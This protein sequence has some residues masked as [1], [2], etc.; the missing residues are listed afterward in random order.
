MTSASR[1]SDW[2]EWGANMH[3]DIVEALEDAGD[4]TG[5]DRVAGT[6]PKLLA[7]LTLDILSRGK[8]RGG[9]A[10]SVIKEFWRSRSFMMTPYVAKRIMKD[11]WKLLRLK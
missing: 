10:R 1:C 4:V 6:G 3:A 2:Q 5:A 11:G 7:Q 9:W 8:G